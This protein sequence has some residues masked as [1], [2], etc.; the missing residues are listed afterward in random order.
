MTD[1]KIIIGNK[2]LSNTHCWS[3]FGPFLTVW[4]EWR[5][6]IL[7]SLLLFPC[8]GIETEFQGEKVGFF[9]FLQTHWQHPVG[10]RWGGVI[11]KALDGCL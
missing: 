4:V 2:I 9:Q 8:L 5:G 7:K 11:I 3:N 1:F 6:P 10:V